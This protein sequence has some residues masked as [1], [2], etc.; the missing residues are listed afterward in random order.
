MRISR[1]LSRMNWLTTGGLV[2]AMAAA[3]SAQ[4]PS[5]PRPGGTPAPAP[6]AGVAPSA[7]PPIVVPPDYVIGIGD[8][9][10]I[11]FWRDADLTR[12]VIVRPDGKITLPLVNDIQAAGLTPEQLRANVTTAAEKFVAGPT[13]NVIVRDIKSRVVYITGMI[14]NP[15]PYPLLTPTTVLQLIATAGGLQDWANT[16]NIL[17]IRKENG[18]DISYKFNYSDVSKG[19]NLQQNIELKPNDSIVVP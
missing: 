18:R 12:D 4:A 3:A 10:S 9:L 2:V 8:G 19:K 14:G 13:V 5:T 6:T 7:A 11:N 1:S 15:G 17:I 16:K